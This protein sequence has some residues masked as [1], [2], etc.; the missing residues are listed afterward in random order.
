MQE[1]AVHAMRVSA[2]QHMLVWV[3][4]RTQV[5]EA[6][7]LQ[8]LEV[9]GIQALVARNTT[10][11]VVPGTAVLAVLRTM[12]WAAPHTLESAVRAMPAWVAPA[13]QALVVGEIVHE[14]VSKDGTTSI[15]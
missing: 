8:V 11:S 5:L 12:E 10:M 7:V 3:G 15:S 13:T 9:R 1:S 14:Y 2:V 6:H 4:P